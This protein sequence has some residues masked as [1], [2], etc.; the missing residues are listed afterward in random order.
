MVLAALT[1]IALLTLSLIAGVV[2]ITRDL[3]FERTAVE[4]RLPASV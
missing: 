1:L 2:V 3:A 4:P